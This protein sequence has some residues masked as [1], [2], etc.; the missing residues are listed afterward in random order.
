MWKSVIDTSHVDARLNCLPYDDNPSK[1]TFGTP[2]IGVSV[3]AVPTLSGTSRPMPASKATSEIALC[4][5]ML[6]R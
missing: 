6:D 5:W 4:A 3:S 2:H 1:K